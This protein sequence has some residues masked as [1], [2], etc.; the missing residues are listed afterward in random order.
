MTFD[1]KTLGIGAV[2]GV[3]GYMLVRKAPLV[4]GVG[5]YLLGV[6][7]ANYLMPSTAAVPRPASSVNPIQGA[8]QTAVTTIQNWRSQ[9]QAQQNAATTAAAVAAEDATMGPVIEMTQ[10]QAA[11]GG[12]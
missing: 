9:A 5:G 4:G 8:L 11:E 12:V 7:A 6:L 2:G 3:A 10:E 1:A